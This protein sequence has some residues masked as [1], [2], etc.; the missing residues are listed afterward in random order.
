MPDSSV[1]I[2]PGAGADIGTVERSGIE[3]QQ[4]LSANHAV[5]LTFETAAVTSSAALP[6]IPATAITA[7][8]Q[9]EGGAIRWRPDGATTAP[10]SSVGMLVPDGY[11]VEMPFGEAGLAAVRVIAASGTPTISVVYS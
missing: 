3:V 10:T 9:V 8:V 6:T 7:F 1:P 2:T 4:V 5:P 11:G